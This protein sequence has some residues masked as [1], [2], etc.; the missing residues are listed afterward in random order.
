MDPN[1]GEWNAFEI[2]MV[3]DLIASH[4]A[5]SAYAN[6]INNKQID[7]VDVLQARFP[8]KEKHNVTNL[9]A[10]LMVEKTHMMLSGNQHA[11]AGSKLVNDKFG[12]PVEHPTMDVLGGDLVEERQRRRFWTT[13]EHRNFLYGLRAYGQSDWKNISKHFV[14]TRTPV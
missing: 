5:K 4:S 14:T 3:N 13:D 10:D 12:M 11:T 8:T 2:K 1:Y 9:Y 6:D 7:I